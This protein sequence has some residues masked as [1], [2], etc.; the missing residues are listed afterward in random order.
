MQPTIDI[1]THAFSPKIADRVLQQLADTYSI[2]PAGSGLL[3]DLR[4]H[5]DAAG[6]DK[7]VVHNAATRP[8]QV[9]PANN[10][11]IQVQ[12]SRPGLY[13]FGTIHPEYADWEAEL[14]RLESYGIHGLKLHADFQGFDLADPRLESVFA[15]LEGRFVVM[16]HVGNEQPPDRS[17]SSPHKVARIKRKFPD[18]NLIAAH[19]GGY[20]HWP[21]VVEQYRDLDIYIDTSSSL[22][23]ISQSDLEAIFNTI[24]R[25][26]ICFG[27]DYPLYRPAETLQQLG[28]RLNLSDLQ[29]KQLLTN[30]NPLL[31]AWDAHDA[32]R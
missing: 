26:H 11:A 9:M 14:N 27:S 19:F 22:D 6:I 30:A 5:L 8:A 3:D 17:P 13:S 12:T 20:L 4:R 28:S 10:W 1:H 25:D 31:A 29:I 24:P 16:L 18:L 23:F 32:E 7:A 21:Y 15:A 2:A